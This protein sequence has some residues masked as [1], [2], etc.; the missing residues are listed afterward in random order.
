[1]SAAELSNASIDCAPAS[2]LPAPAPARGW[3]LFAAIGVVWFATAVSAANLQPVTFN[4]RGGPRE[5][6]VATPA[7]AVSGARPLVLLL[8]GET[9]T[10]ANALGGGHAPSPLS[11]WLQ[12]VDREQILVAALQPLKDE[13]G[14]T[15]WQDCRPDPS[16]RAKSSDAGL[17]SAVISGLTAAGRADAHRTYVMGVSD[18]AIMAYRLAVELVPTPAA[19]AAVAGSM[20]EHSDCAGKVRPVSVLLVHGTSDPI[21]PYAGGAIDGSGRSTGRVLGFEATRDFWLKVDGLAQTEPVVLELPHHGGG[22][23]HAVRST[24]G[25]DAGPQV[26]TIIIEGGGHAEPS[27]R[28]HYDKANLGRF[29]TQS[30]DFES[31]EAAWSFFKDKA[32]AGAA[33]A[34]K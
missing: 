20:A 32:A 11:A 6:I 30:R 12:I 2:R 8:P 7:R 17:A 24:Y 15:G 9:T 28:Y 5:Y 22:S 16:G 31:A 21:V 18:G 26:E 13:Q 1:V 29:G 4:M 23:T 33:P 10:A 27:L 14:R 25:P 19:V 34:S 3:P